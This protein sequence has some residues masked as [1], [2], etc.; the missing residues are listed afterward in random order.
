MNKII[1]GFAVG[2][3]AIFAASNAWAVMLAVDVPFQYNFD[4][5]GSADK[6]SGFKAG[7]ALPFFPAFLIGVA[8]EDYEIEEEV[9][10]DT[11]TIAFAV[12]D[13][14]V[15]IPFVLFTLGLGAGQGEAEFELPLSGIKETADVSQIFASL[16]IPFGVFDLHLGWHQVSVDK[17]E[18]VIGTTPVEI[19]VS[20]T[21][22]SLGIA[23]FFK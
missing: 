2:L 18:T 13:I 9:G 16:G 5:G 17:I 21:M 20:G 15:E 3:A 7:I 1:C 6:V 12:N 8:V 10:N 14:I 4:D 23:V 22:W 19:D 11:A